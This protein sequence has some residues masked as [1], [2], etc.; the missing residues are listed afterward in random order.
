SACFSCSIFSAA[1]LIFDP[2]HATCTP[3]ANVRYLDCVAGSLFPGQNCEPIV[4]CERSFV[5]GGRMT[6]DNEAVG[7]RPFTCRVPWYEPKKNSLFRLMGPPSVPPNWF[8]FRVARDCPAAFL[9]NELAL[10]MSL[11]R[12]SQASP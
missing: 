8:C 3:P 10:K 2:S 5:S 6:V 9:K 11:R 7:S 4:A 1:G 12:N